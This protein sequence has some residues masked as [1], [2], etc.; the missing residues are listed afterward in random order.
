MNSGM[1]LIWAING[2]AWVLNAAIDFSKT[3]PT[4]GFIAGIVMFLASM[5]ILVED[6]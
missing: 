4:Y 6:P 1:R 3:G 2:S 5:A